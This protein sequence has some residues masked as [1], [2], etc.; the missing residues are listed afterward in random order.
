[1]DVRWPPRPPRQEV[2][3]LARQLRPGGVLREGQAITIGGRYTLTVARHGD[4]ISVYGEAR[5]TGDHIDDG[6]RRDME[7]RDIAAEALLAA[8]ARDRNDA[9]HKAL[10][11]ALEPLVEIAAKLRFGHDRDAF[12]AHVIRRL[13]RHW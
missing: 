13:T 7:A 4:T 12:L 8:R 2:L 11:D 10:D 3:R 1:M 9:R 5:Y 6:L